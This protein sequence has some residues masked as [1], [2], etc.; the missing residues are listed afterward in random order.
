MICLKVPKGEGEAVRYALNR[1]GL[2][3]KEKKML[4]DGQFIY[5]PIKNP[6]SDDDRFAERYEVVDMHPPG[7]TVFREPFPAIKKALA[8]PSDLERLLPHKWERLGDVVII[9]LPKELWHDAPR[10]GA[11]YAKELRAKAVL[12]E[13]GVIAGPFRRPNVQ[14]IYGKDT[15]TVHKEGGVL[16]KLDPMKVMFSSG[17]LKEKSRMARLDCRGETVV[18]MFAGIGYFTMPLAKKAKAK[19][20]IA[21]EINP[22]SYHYLIENIRL[23]RLEDV[24]EPFL[25]DNRDLPGKAIADR[26]VMGYVGST[27]EYLPK[28]LEIVRPNGIVHYHDVAGIE[29]SPKKLLDAIA[30]ACD[31]R[32]YEVVSV[33][34]VKSYAPCKVHLVVDF[35]VLE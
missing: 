5:I 14:L 15:E 3:V 7:R 18:D 9:K 1:K 26:V 6:P 17:N 16:Y 33:Q 22:D 10:I 29:E 24:V 34:E 27:E 30:K 8:L 20:V 4:D 19:K 31:G 25:G 23:N 2:V 13:V 35:K 28:A 11:A 21:C 12:N 32:R